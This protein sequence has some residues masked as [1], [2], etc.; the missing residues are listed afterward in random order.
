MWT[1]TEDCVT[2][3]RS[4]EAFH[5]V[6]DKGYGTLAWKHKYRLTVNTDIQQKKDLTCMRPNSLSWSF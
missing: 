5:K 3:V 2:W 4:L 1:P 6:I